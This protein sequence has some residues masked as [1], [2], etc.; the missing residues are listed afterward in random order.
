MVLLAGEINCVQSGT[1]FCDVHLKIDTPKESKHYNIIY[2]III[3]I[4]RVKDRM[5]TNRRNIACVATN[6]GGR[7]MQTLWTK[8]QATTPV[9]F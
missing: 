7:L 2:I 4:G 3:I 9:R 6:K 8:N 1:I 5:S